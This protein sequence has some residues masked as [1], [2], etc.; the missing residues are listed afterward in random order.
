MRVI[1]FGCSATY[2]QSLEDCTVDT[3]LPGPTPSKFA[4]PNLVANELGTTCVNK[5][6]PGCGNL[7]ILTEILNFDF[8]PSDIAIVQWTW[9]PRAL[10]VSEQKDFLDIGPWMTEDFSPVPLKEKLLEYLS[11]KANT[12]VSKHKQHAI[13][14]YNIHSD[15]HLK[16]TSW[17]YMDYAALHLART[18]TTKVFLTH[19]YWDADACMGQDQR[20]ILEV[21]YDLRV[22][23]GADNMHPGLESHKIWANKILTFLKE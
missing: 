20:D 3:I 21:F 18:N 12:T 2:G 19:E 9:H 14:F 11:K 7:R 4:Y 15:Y 22:D 16:M 23:F 5:S 10:L 17:M 6:I 13:D 1:A 8:E